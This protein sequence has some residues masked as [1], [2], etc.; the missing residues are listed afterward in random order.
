VPALPPLIFGFRHISQTPFY[1]TGGR[2]YHIP[3]SESEY[4]SFHV[5]QEDKES[6]E[7]S[8]HPRGGH[9]YYNGRDME[10]FM[11]RTGWLEK[12]KSQNEDWEERY[13]DHVEAQERIRT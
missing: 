10:R 13:R 11:R 6:P 2:L 9:N 7:K 8:Y 5:S 3:P 4:A 1:F 12:I